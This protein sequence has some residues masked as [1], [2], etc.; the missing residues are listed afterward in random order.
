MYNKRQRQ[1]KSSMLF[2]FYK[3]QNSVILEETSMVLST[4]FPSLVVA[5]MRFQPLIFWRVKKH[6]LSQ[7]L[8]Y[9]KDMKSL[10]TQMHLPL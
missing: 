10:L 6:L 7:G 2:Q 9:F 4:P 1:S 5:L 3:L 8:V